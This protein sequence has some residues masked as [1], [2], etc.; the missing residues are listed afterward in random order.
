MA[1][2]HSLIKECKPH[3]I[4]LQEVHSY[5]AANSLAAATGYSLFVSTLPQTRDRIMAV[6]SPL[7]GTAVQETK[8][9]QA[10]LATVGALPFINIH[11]PNFDA[12][13]RNVFF[14]GLRPFLNTPI[15]PII[16][17]DFN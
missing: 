9:G 3:L 13:E 2:L 14:H 16:L 4:F 6:L 7:P 10:Q 1:G 11:A 8:P 17:G 12:H 15:S 5:N